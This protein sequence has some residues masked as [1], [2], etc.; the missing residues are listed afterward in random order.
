MALAFNEEM[1]TPWPDGARIDN[2]HLLVTDAAPH[3]RRAVKV[4]VR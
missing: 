1:Q 2:M 3:M 4:T